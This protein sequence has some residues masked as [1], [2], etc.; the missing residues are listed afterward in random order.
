MGDCSDHLRESRAQSPAECQSVLE[1]IQ[2][3]VHGMLEIPVGFIERA[4]DVLQ[5]HADPA[6]QADLVEPAYLGFGVQ[7]VPPAGATG[8]AQQFDLVGEPQRPHGESGRPGQFPDPESAFD[9]HSCNA[10]T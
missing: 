3:L 7:P 9:C 5:R 4:G 8:Q 10:R 2:V 1:Q 6:E